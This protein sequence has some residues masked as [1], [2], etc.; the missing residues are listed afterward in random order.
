VAETKTDVKPKADAKKKE[1][2][3][4]KTGSVNLDSLKDVLHQVVNSVAI[5]EETTANKL[6]NAIDRLHSSGDPEEAK[7]EED[8][9]AAKEAE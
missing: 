8:K 9:K 4:F 6:H 5:P 3:G 2:S 7:A 1:D